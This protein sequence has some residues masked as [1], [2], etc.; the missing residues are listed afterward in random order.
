MG[1]GQPSDAELIRQCR[2]GDIERFSLLV[3][4]YQN[5]IYNLALRLL[6][7]R[8]D[9]LDAA[10]ETFV[11][12][13]AAL[14]EFQVDRPFAPWL[15]RIA[16][17]LCFGLLRKR[18]P[19]T[20]ELDGLEEGAAD[21]L[22]AE[23]SSPASAGSDPERWLEQSLRD[24]EIQRAVLALPEPY[25]TVVLLRHTEEM[26]YE[27]IA[28]VLQMPLGSVKTCLHRARRRLRIA[29]Q[30]VI[31]GSELREDELRD[32]PPIADPG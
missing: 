6:D 15:Y 11:R 19:E 16:T 7:D 21:L 9:A 8:D 32:S 27:A 5:R 14:T 2:Q 29:L 4:R 22:L 30:P 25:R 28:S 1:D 24:E 20:I 31:D 12:A 17:N 18:R 26:S 10:Q 23:I 3:T 13:Y